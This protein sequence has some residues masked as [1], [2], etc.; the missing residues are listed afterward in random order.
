MSEPRLSLILL[1][2]ALVAL[3]AGPVLRE[4]GKRVPQLLPF[5]DG[6]VIGTIGALAFFVLLPEAYASAGWGAFAAAAFGLIAFAILEKL[7]HVSHAK[8]HAAGRAVAVTGLLAHMFFDGVALFVGG[9]A[10]MLGMGVALHRIPASI[11]VWWL[12]TTIS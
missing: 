4:A 9:D 12:V 2:F 6:F 7:S 5:I 11:G 8:L 1:G 3:G 10:G